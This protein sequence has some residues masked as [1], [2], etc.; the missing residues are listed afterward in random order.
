MLININIFNLNPSNKAHEAESFLFN[1]PSNNQET[2]RILCNP[3]VDYRFPKRPAPVPLLSQSN[4]VHA[5]PSHVLK[6]HFNIILPSMP[7]SSNWSQVLVL[8][9]RINKSPRYCEMFRNALSFTVRIYLRFVLPLT[10]RNISCWLSKTSYSIYSQIPSISRS[11]S[12]IRK[13]RTRHGL[14]T[15]THIM[16]IST[17]TY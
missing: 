8:Y 1:R 10:W 7:R 12:S 5:S 3:T 13:L 6:I 15:E 11:R 16:I 9:Q 4:P 2:P 17:F 14:V